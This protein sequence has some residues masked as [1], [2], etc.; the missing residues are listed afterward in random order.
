MEWTDKAL[1]LR[2]GQFKEIDLKLRLLTPQRGLITAFAFG[3]RR[4]MRR[5]CGCLDI[6][7]SIVCRVRSARNGG[8]LALEEASLIRGTRR[9]RGD[10]GRLGQVVNCLRFLEVFGVHGEESG[11]A[12]ALAEQVV[13]LLEESDQPPPMLTLLFRLRVAADQGFALSLRACARCGREA[14]GA[15][16][17]AG[18]AGADWR[19]LLDEGLILCPNCGRPGRYI[20]DI[21]PPAL[22]FLDGVQHTSP[23]EWTAERLSPAER[24]QCGRAVDAFVQYHLGISWED[25]RFR[26]V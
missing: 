14:A 11:R 10:V 23:E 24:R 12:H 5:F 9:L 13:A 21:S 4:S 17:A 7:N 22:E 8:W 3:G 18:A 6:C 25:G 15:S 1:V 19:F 26:R 2:V 16:G 20:L